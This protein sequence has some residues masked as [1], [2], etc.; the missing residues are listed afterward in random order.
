MRDQHPIESGLK[1]LAH[2]EAGALEGQAFWVRLQASIEAPTQTLPAARP[3]SANPLI[4]YAPSRRLLLVLTAT[5]ALMLLL[6]VTFTLF[7]GASAHWAD[8]LMRTGQLEAQ[9]EAWKSDSAHWAPALAEHLAGVT[10]CA[11]TAASVWWMER[12]TFRP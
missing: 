4:R 5:C 11:W 7:E 1:A 12:I 10:L 2:E 9:H 3:A 8:A 6:G